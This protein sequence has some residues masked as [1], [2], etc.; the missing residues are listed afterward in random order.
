MRIN[1]PT[2]DVIKVIADEVNPPSVGQLVCIL[3]NRAVAADK[4]ANLQ[5]IGIAKSVQNSD[6]Y[7]QLTGKYANTSIGNTFWLGANGSLLNSPPVTGM[8]QE[9]ANRLDDNT[10]LIAIDKT[11]IL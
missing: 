11:V 5:A 9:V 3:N 2:A 4:D 8:V 10:I 6:V 7:V 1:L